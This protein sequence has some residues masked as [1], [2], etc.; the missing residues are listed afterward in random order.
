L[1]ADIGGT[2]ARFALFANGAIT[3]IR[4]LDANQ[5]P[6]P[7]HAVRAYLKQSQSAPLDAAAIAIA[8]P[9]LGDEVHMTN[10]PWRFSIAALRSEL[11]LRRLIV[12]NDFTALAMALRHLPQSELKQIGGSTQIANVPIALI[13]AGTGLGVSGCCHSI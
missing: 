2:N 3:A 13:G 5:Y 9:L 11:G 4:T 12:L 8:A 7:A 1:L 10:N 6:T